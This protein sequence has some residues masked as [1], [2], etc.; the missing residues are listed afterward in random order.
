MTDVTSKLDLKHGSPSRFNSIERGRRIMH[1]QLE[2]K[3]HAL[4][5]QAPVVNDVSA[6][7][8]LVEKID[9]TCDRK[10]W[11]ACRLLFAMFS[12]S[13]SLL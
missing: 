13:T 5:G 10:D 8:T 2:W 12:R 9:D 4:S 3:E 1:D 11:E 7:R 6:I